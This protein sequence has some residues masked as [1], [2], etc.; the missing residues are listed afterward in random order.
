MKCPN[1]ETENRDS[2][3][4]C[5]ECGFPLSKAILE[6]SNAADDKSADDEETQDDQPER[7]QDQEQ[8]DEPD[9]TVEPDAD[10]TMPIPDFPTEEIGSLDEEEPDGEPLDETDGEAEAPDEGDAHG[11]LA[12][13]EDGAALDEGDITRA[14]PDLSGY[15]TIDESIV[16]EDYHKPA[17]NWHDGHTMR[18]ER[19]Q[20]DEAPKSKDFLAS[21]TAERRH[22]KKKIAII[23]GII[24]AVAAIAAF[25]S[26]SLQLWGG[27]SVP[28][29]TGLTEAEATSILKDEGFNVRSLEV[30]SDD[31]EGL[32]LVMDPSAGSRAEKE[33]E[34]VI[35][36]ATARLV[37]DIVGKTKD[38]AAKLLDDSGFANVVYTEELSDNPVGTVVSV[39]PEVGK[40]AKSSDEI[41]VSIAKP[42]TVPDISNKYLEDAQAAIEE[43]GL[44]PEVDYVRTEDYPDG[45]IMGTVPAAGTQVHKGDTVTIQISHSRE[46]ECI[47]LTQAYLAP[48]STIAL[49]GYNF[50]VQS[51]DNVSYMGNSTVAYT[52]T[53]RPFVSVFGETA[54]FSP[55]S[56]PGQIVWSDSNQ[57]ESMS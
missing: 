57:I 37:P 10:A 13:G 17:N 30:K 50:E 23:V 15:D 41:H 32:V 51:L 53:A 56:I 45:I 8:A 16:A 5:D 25:V 28:D 21:A 24:V 54:Y 44:T 36:I 42:Y 38:E 29:V 12:D 33:S 35:H 2:A 6:A 40:R 47:S 49:N 48:G 27:I 4:Y 39:T 31:T 52:V 1:C 14:M 7:D 55:Q 11:D 18:M 19:I 9:E 3:K 43:A 26:Y 46:A 34:I 20:D 22:N